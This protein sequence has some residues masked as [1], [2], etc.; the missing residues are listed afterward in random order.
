MSG[1]LYKTA[2]PEIDLQTTQR[3]QDKKT[4]SERTHLFKI[5]TLQ[6]YTYREL[7]GM[8]S[9][10]ILLLVVYSACLGTSDA[11]FFT[12]KLDCLVSQWTEW[13]EPYGFGQISRNRAILRHPVNGGADCPP[14][15]I[16]I[17]FTGMIYGFFPNNILHEK[18]I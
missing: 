12:S 6:K 7:N 13:S 4:A 3:T 5:Y 10:V 15:L 1:S 17:H 14:D 9:R 2:P 8:E 11:F 16:D 18:N